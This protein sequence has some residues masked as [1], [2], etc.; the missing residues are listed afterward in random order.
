MGSTMASDAG[1]LDRLAARVRRPLDRAW[2]LRA[3]RVDDL[4][5]LGA[6]VDRTSKSGG[7]PRVLV[8]S[9][10]MWT[11]HTAYESVI[12]QALRL[13]GADVAMVTCGGG[14]PICELGWGRR[15]SPRPCDRC[16]FFTDRLATRGGFPLLRLADEFPWGAF[17]A[18]APV[19]GEAAVA[20][21]LG[22]A[23]VAST[24]WFL[25]S[26]DTER[27]PEGPQIERDFGIAVRAV[28]AA[29]GRILDRVRPDVVFALNGLFAAEQA[30]RAV[31]A[32]RGVRVVTYEI[33]PRQGALVFGQATPAP[34]MTMDGLA[35]EQAGQPL[36]EAEADALDEMLFGRVTGAGSHER[37]FEGAQEHAGDAVREALG[38]RSGVR[39][40]SAFTNLAWD[41]AL[42]GKDVAFK[43]QF[44]WLAR[45][46]EL[47]ADRGDR[48]LVIRIHPA[49]SRW[50]TGQ[51]VES[52][53]VARLG[54][55]PRNVRLIRPDDST[56]SYGLLAISDLALCYTTTVGLE[57]AVRG[58]SVA[59]GGQTH[60][61]G[62]GFTHDIDSDAALARLIADPPK[63]TPHQVELARRYAFAFFFRRMIPFRHVRNEGGSVAGIPR[64]ADELLPGQDPYLDFVCERILFGGEFFLPRSLALVEQ[65]GD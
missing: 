12:A 17:S 55:L 65:G 42:L 62:R 18:A 34:E 30:V 53:L 44:D 32:E 20:P 37:Y 39:V 56:S 21:R 4:D 6:S 15:V 28:E 43:S 57:A 29:I 10:R 25:K 38:I 1:P 41:T 45:A 3:G 58:V 47:V 23:S 7:G 64:S 52:E 51:P 54:E 8:L 35:D 24:A 13:R 40:L 14:Q 60:Y 49:E 46:C 36:S 48:T 5:R 26:A 2:Y 59:V 61:R 27:A 22:E 50:G 31:A 16:G 63:M 9:L 33:S 11:H 19:D